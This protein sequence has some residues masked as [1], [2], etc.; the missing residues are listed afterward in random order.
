MTFPFESLVAE[1]GELGLI[2]A[3]LLGFG[4]GFVL[5]RAGFGRSTKLAAQFYFHDMTVFKVMFS[6]IVTAMLGL[7]LVSGLGFADLTAL[8]SQIVSWTYIWPMLIG[9]LGLGAGFI[10]SGYCPGTSVVGA[11]S[12][13]IDA[14]V[15]WAGVAIGSLIYSAIQP[16]IVAFHNSGELGA[17]FVYNY[18]GVPAPVLALGVVLMAVGA[19]IGAEKVEAIFTRRKDARDGATAVRPRVAYPM[20]RRV[21]F[22]TFGFFALLA[23]ATMVVPTPTTDASIREPE[24]VGPTALAHQVLDEPWNVRIV[25]IRSLEDC[26]DQRIPGSECVPSDSVANLGLEFIPAQK[27]LIVVTGADQ[28]IPAEVM[29]YKGRV[30]ALENGFEAWKDYALTVPEP[31]GPAASEEDREAYRFQAALFAALTGETG[32]AP[33]PPALTTAYVPKKKKGGGGCN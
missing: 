26:S 24:L 29:A 11:A 4:F 27:D 17:A 13:H 10:I 16:K 25:D 5:E 14:W 31:P 21:A 30:Y 2:V 33:P 19:F 7:I 23:L 6:A 18:L 8:S 12:G 32:S 28:E 1:N 15:T 22:A 20:A 3:V 9:G